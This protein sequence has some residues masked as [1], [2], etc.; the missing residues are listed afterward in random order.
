MDGASTFRSTLKGTLN[1]TLNKT[2]Y[3]TA[4]STYNFGI[5]SGTGS[6]IEITSHDTEKQVTISGHK[7][8]IH[9]L[10]LPDDFFDE[11][12]VEKHG[13]DY[14]T[15]NMS[16]DNYIC[17]WQLNDLLNGMGWKLIGY[18]NGNT[19][20]GDLVRELWSLSSKQGKSKKGK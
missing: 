15:V 20:G 17:R 13:G 2:L 14:I 12:R 5:H 3:S 19:D 1:G 6:T 11:E 16:G 18:S 9:S 7:E 10:H 8:T 4:K